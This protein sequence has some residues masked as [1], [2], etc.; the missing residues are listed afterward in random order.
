MKLGK[1][2]LGMV[3]GAALAA[4]GQDLGDAANSQYSGGFLPPAPAN[5][6]RG[7]LITE[8][9]FGNAN[10]QRGFSR[11]VEVDGNMVQIRNNDRV[12]HHIAS[13]DCPSLNVGMINPGQTMM[14]QLPA[15]FSS[16]T[17]YDPMSQSG[18]WRVV[19]TDAEIVGPR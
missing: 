1:L 8:Q 7:V 16:C 19:L 4:C 13:Q 12:A 11:I 6:E 14:L 5:I 17:L 9:G 10:V 2:V 15:D 18:R 3:C